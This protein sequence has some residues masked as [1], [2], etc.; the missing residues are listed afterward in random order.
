MGS[1][2]SLVFFWLLMGVV[3]GIIANSKGRDALA[4]GLYGVAIW[5]IALVHILTKPAT[6]AAVAAQ[7][8][9]QDG[10]EKKCPECAEMIKADAKVC[11]FCGNR[12][13][14]EPVEEEFTYPDYVPK[15]VPTTWQKLWWNPHAVPKRRK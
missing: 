12:Q 8:A 13:F 4:W 14:P 9:V 6:G 3:V 2:M 10:P 11:R 15:P 7:R 5:P 1:A